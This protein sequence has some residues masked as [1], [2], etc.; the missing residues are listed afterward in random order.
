[1][2]DDLQQ[3]K[4]EVE[5]LRAVTEDTNKLVHRMRRG[6]RWALLFRII[7]W[8]TILGVTGAAY[9]YYLQPYVGQAMN[10]YNNTKDLQVQIQKFFA[11]FGRTSN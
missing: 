3:L 11:Q 9:Y 8:L 4:Q 1:M 7:W 6:G 2:A 5:K 10:A